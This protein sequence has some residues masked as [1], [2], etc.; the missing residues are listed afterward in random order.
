MSRNQQNQW[1]KQEVFDVCR[2]TSRLTVVIRNPGS[3]SINKCAP[4]MSPAGAVRPKSLSVELSQ[5]IR[6]VFDRC[7]NENIII[8]LDMY[9]QYMVVALSMR[10]LVHSIPFSTTPQ[11]SSV[12]VDFILP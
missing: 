4:K 5:N 3:V 2:K 8:S 7:V 1:N 11:S 12:L 6:A 9:I 10:P